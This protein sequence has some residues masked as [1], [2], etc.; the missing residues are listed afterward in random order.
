MVVALLG[1]WLTMRVAGDTPIGRALR[2]WTV[3]KPAAR[4]SRISRVQIALVLLLA[5][6]GGGA[7]WLLGHDGLSLYGMAM[8]ELAGMLASVEMT[9]FV[10]AAITVTLVATSVRWR[11]VRGAVAQRLGQARKVR[12]RRPRRPARKPAND[13]G[14]GPGL[15]FAA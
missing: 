4:L 7:L 14:G 11:A 12:A 5:A 15:A 3:E 10:D 8:P 6:I 9:A 1:L 2:R 13:D